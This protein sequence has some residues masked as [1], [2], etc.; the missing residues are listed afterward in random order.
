MPLPPS[1]PTTELKRRNGVA[2]TTSKPALRMLPAMVVGRR[3][4]SLFCCLRISAKTFGISYT[5][6]KGKRVRES[7]GTS[8][9]EEA[10]RI[11]RDKQG[12]IARGEAILRRADRVLYE[13]VRSDLVTYY[14]VFGKRDMVEAGGRLAHLDPHFTGWKVVD[15]D[16]G[17]SHGVRP[18]AAARPRLRRPRSTENLPRCRRC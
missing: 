13:E 18:G 9:K 16:E 1:D 12:R 4:T 7:T 2:G 17:R 14:A 5:D 8:D 11:L 15:I 3:N 10:I 6:T